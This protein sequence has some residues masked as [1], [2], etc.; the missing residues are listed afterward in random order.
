MEGCVAM[1]LRLLETRILGDH[2]IGSA[3]VLLS[4]LPTKSK[5]DRWFE[6]TKKSEKKVMA[7]VQL[8]VQLVPNETLVKVKKF[9]FIRLFVFVLMLMF[10]LHP[11]IRSAKE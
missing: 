5:E 3:V 11:N 4:S 8:R 2:S 1:K 9:C 6:L 10:V 7:Q